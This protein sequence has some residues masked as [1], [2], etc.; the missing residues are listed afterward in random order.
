MGDAQDAKRMF[1]EA[2]ARLGRETQFHID[3]RYHHFYVNKIVIVTIM[4]LL[5]VVAVVNVYLVRILYNDLTGI[6]GNMDS[7]RHNMQVVSGRMQHITD[8]VHEFEKHMRHMDHIYAH[9]G[10]MAVLLP[11]INAD[12][13]NI[14]MSIDSIEGDMLGLSQGMDY[15]DLRFNEMTQGV[16]VMRANMRQIARPMGAMNPFMP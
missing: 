14:S 10:A 15:I 11:D 16:A 12:M 7:M 8:N 9:T 13:Q 4:A 1:I 5:L 3:E 2:V 6:V